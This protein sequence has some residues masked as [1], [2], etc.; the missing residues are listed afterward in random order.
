MQYRILGKTGLS[1]S[2]VA[3]GA[4]PISGL[5]VGDDAARQRDVVEH[6]L[7]RGVNWFDTA[8]TYGG[9]RSESQLGRTL[10]E[11]RVADRVHVATKVRLM[12]DDLA[13]IPRAVRRSFYGSLQRLGLSRVSLLQLHNSITPRRG[14]EPTSITPHDV[15]GRQGVAAAL[16]ELRHDGLVEHFGMTGIGDPAAMKEVI[17]A[18]FFASIQVPYHLLNDSAGRDANGE[19][20]GETNYGN[21]INACARRGM[22]VFVIRVLAGGALAEAPPSPHTYK[23]PFFP[24]DLY[25]RDCL[26]AARLRAALAADRRLPVEALRF[27]LAHPQ[28]TSAIV[29]FG[30]K[31]QIDDAMAALEPDSAPIDWTAFANERFALPEDS[32]CR[33][34]VV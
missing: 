10:A 31:R 6:A 11:L 29:G 24:L 26:R 15:L 17:A 4:G 23:T 1:V 3:F 2:A 5:L 33:M 19:L 14:D 16:E 13:D 8:A 7:S 9:G 21:V 20:A 22:G 30:E 18:G 32:S 27:A 28:V 12:P 25:R 34:P